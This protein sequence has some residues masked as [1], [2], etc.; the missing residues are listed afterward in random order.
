MNP[1][2]PRHRYIP[3]PEARVWKDGRLYL[4]G[5]QDRPGS[6]TYCSDSYRFFSTGDLIEW[7]DHG[8]SFCKPGGAFESFPDLY[9]PDC[10]CKDGVYHLFF[11]GGAGSEGVA[12]SDCPAGPFSDPVPVAGADGSGIDPAVLV[13]D[14][15]TAYLY[16]GQFSLQGAKLTG[17]MRAIVP[18]SH[19]MALLTEQAH[20]FHEGASIRKVRG[21]YYLVFTDVSR[22]LATCLSYAVSDSPLGPFEK[23]GVILD[24]APCDPRSWNN[25]GSLCEFQGRWYLFYHRS[26][27]N[28]R[29]NRRACVEPVT[30]LPDG[31]I[32]EIEMTTQGAEGP[33]PAA[34]TMEA[35]RACFLYGGIHTRLEAG[36]EFL[37][38]TGCADF[39]SFKY[40]RFAG[41][42]EFVT[43]LRGEGELQVYLDQPYGVPIAVIPVRSPGTWSTVAAT[44]APAH[45]I[46]SVHLVFNG[47]PVDLLDFRWRAEG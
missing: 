2:L 21:R 13:D 19:R 9:A 29:F 22:G 26:S 31:T 36:R 3:D 18:E 15:G 25:H 1:I 45:G 6:G 33:V 30:I 46:H 12:V 4:Y 23:M 34:R 16:W 38:A 43:T 11:C 14:D 44:H 20:G 32:P 37:A 5:S 40:L 35:W 24:N 47:Q 7:T 27:L 17:D 42:T 39:A 10:V 28:E 41:E 8:T